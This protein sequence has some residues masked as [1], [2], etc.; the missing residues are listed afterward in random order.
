MLNYTYN[1]L[2]EISIINVKK[3]GVL[4]KIALFVSFFKSPQLILYR[5][6]MP[7]YKVDINYIL[8]PEEV[9]RMIEVAERERDKALI[10]VLW[11][12]GARP[13][14]VIGLLRKDIKI[15]DMKIRITIETKKLKK[16]TFIPHKR[17]LVFSYNP[18]NPDPIKTTLI[19]YVEKIANP[20]FPLFEINDSR[21]RQ[22]IYEISQKALG[23]RITPYSFRH[24][25]L[26]Y[27]AKKGLTPIELMYFKGSADTRSVSKYLHAK[28]FVVEE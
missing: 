25:R 11:L 26:T 28:P 14:E 7:K 17:E 18:A 22:L 13:S 3:D 12:T 23:F 4:M 19:R 2:C 15:E 9:V 8:K 5:D 24:S 6:N 21:V 20:D 16:G 10:S 27:L 1:R